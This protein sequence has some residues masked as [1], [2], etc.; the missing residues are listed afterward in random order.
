MNIYLKIDFINSIAPLYPLPGAPSRAADLF[1]IGAC[2]CAQPF[3]GPPWSA[4]PHAHP[5]V[6][7]SLRRRTHMRTHMGTCAAIFRPGPKSQRK[8]GKNHYERHLGTTCPRSWLQDAPSWAQD[9][10]G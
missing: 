5:H 1:R 6:Q 9:A 8:P 7:M 2:T 10:A 4:H 3:L